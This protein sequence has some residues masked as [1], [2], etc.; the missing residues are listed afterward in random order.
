MKSSFFLV[1][2]E[3][4][5]DPQQLAWFSDV[6]LAKWI[7]DLPAAN[8]GLST[9]LF[10]EMLTELLSIEMPTAR[11]LS[12]LELL[13]ASFLSLEDYLRAK[14]IQ[15]GFPK[16][17]TERKIINIL[18]V[19][20]KQFTIGYW[21]VVR[22]L[23]RK[24]VGWLQ[25]KTA[26]LSIQRTVEG[27]SSIVI[28]HYMMNLPV[29][30]WVWIDLHSLYKL[31]I[32][33]GKLT[34]K[35][36][37]QLNLFGGITVID[38]YKQILLLS[39]AYPS[40]LMQKEFL[41]VYQFTEKLC[42]LVQIEPKPV[43]DQTIQCSISL[44]E[45]LPPSFTLTV[46]AEDYQYQ[47]SAKIYLNL[48]KLHKIIKQPD[49]YC[50]KDEVRFSSLEARK[51][52]DPN[53]KLS[54]ELFD[55]LMHRWNGKEPQGTALF[56]DRLDRYIAIGLNATH[57]LQ[58]LS[59]PDIASRNLEVLAQTYSDR[60]LIS[61]FADKEGVLSIGSLV[62]FRQTGGQLHHR[63]LGVICKILLPKQEN[64]L[65]FEIT[66]L[67]SQSFSVTYQHMQDDEDAE[68]KKALLYG[69]KSQNEER[70]FIILES[71][72]IKDGD[73]LR[74]NMGTESFPI[75]LIGRKN[76]GLGYWQFECRRI[77][78]DIPQVQ[79]K[80]KGYDFI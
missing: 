60:A 50:S 65:V 38:R 55:Y 24:D 3:Q 78:E 8:P 25:G 15:S 41:Q 29:P 73:I 72:M 56:V 67:A 49:K 51:N 33:L 18:L 5:N 80:K 34:T 70:S 68:R 31:S 59:L 47:D 6:N 44:D 28:T 4:I 26:A 27:L 36:S 32:K 76:I 74:M 17:D 12:T 54:P 53:Q 35:L 52:A 39:L 14:L 48:G 57:E 42:E 13:K 30:N 16:G 20:E 22:E 7:D 77:L 61:N 19:L 43:A 66:V 46:H 75:I 71:F 63:S 79:G 69:I 58:D 40:G 62:S 1:I 23:T 10:Q 2:P 64:N 11:R 9:R 21:I 37:G 45:D